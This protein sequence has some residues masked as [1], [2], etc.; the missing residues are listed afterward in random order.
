[1]RYIYKGRS[2]FI[3]MLADDDLQKKT[4]NKSLTMK[5]E[6]QGK[7]ILEFHLELMSL[8]AIQARTEKALKRCKEQQDLKTNSCCR[9]YLQM[10]NS[11]YSGIVY[12]IIKKM[13]FT[14]F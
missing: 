3:K 13:A 4:I 9:S 14:S 8:D 10:L 1:M 5:F 7:T 11:M 6:E 12:E 2:V